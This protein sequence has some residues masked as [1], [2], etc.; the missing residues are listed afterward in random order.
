MFLKHSTLPLNL[1]TLQEGCQVDRGVLTAPGSLE[2]ENLEFDIF[3]VAFRIS[4]RYSRFNWIGHFFKI[5]FPL[6][7][8]A[9]KTGPWCSQQYHQK[10]HF[11]WLSWGECTKCASHSSA[12]IR[13]SLY[14][15]STWRVHRVGAK[16][17]ELHL[18]VPWL[19]GAGT[20]FLFFYSLHSYLNMWGTTQEKT[21]QLLF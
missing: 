8:P 3:A 21:S 17:C 7:S 15:F 16:V 14:P 19:D 20:F 6:C 4:L 18:W 2:S 12:A 5:L 10:P 9:S 13:H 11:L 1:V